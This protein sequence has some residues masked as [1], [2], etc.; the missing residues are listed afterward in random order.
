[1]QRWWLIFA[2]LGLAHV[3]STGHAIDGDLYWDEAVYANISAHPLKTDFYAVGDATF[4]RHPPLLFGLQVAASALPVPTELA[5]RSTSILFSL[6]GLA[7]LFATLLALRR[8]GLGVLLV[9]LLVAHTVFQQYSQ[10]ATMYA[11]FFAFSALLLYAVATRSAWLQAIAL[12]LAL[13]THYFALLWLATLLLLDL[14][15]LRRSF[16]S[17]AGPKYG[18]ILLLYLP[19]VI[20][21]PEGMLFHE[22]QFRGLRRVLPSLWNDLN[23][24]GAGLL[25]A[26]AAACVQSL[27]P[28]RFRAMVRG[29]NEDRA[30]LFAFTSA[31]MML[32]VF[33]AAK[34][35]IRYLYFC[36]PIWLGATLI[37]LDRRFADRM[38]KP[39]HRAV[40]VLVVVAGMSVP[41]VRLFG[42]FP[43][44]ASFFDR[45][46]SIHHQAWR[47]AARFVDGASVALRNVRSYYYY[48][49][50]LRPQ[51]PQQYPW[52]DL[53]VY[54]LHGEKTI[55]T[56]RPRYVVLRV[57]DEA[58][59]ASRMPDLGYVPARTLRY[60]VIFERA[61]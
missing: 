23:V 21:L 33:L 3:A 2:V 37:W 24:L 51:R 57:E 15:E 20:H 38:A 55:T 36:F 27:R 54:E 41:N 56:H 6:V 17:R 29:S 28:S 25:A 35:F 26:L 44:T 61:E 39:W 47:D 60:H 18:A 50:Q 9:A 40:A 4:V 7:L 59:M 48:D 30:I 14:L 10:S 11:P 16:I 13:Y 45:N 8:P 22:S 43:Y 1:M 32:T 34:P 58:E 31:A 12:T 5:L 19:W 49:T 42:L 53:G 52:D 46:D